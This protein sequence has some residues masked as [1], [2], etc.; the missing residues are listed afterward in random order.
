M[1]QHRSMRFYK[2]ARP[3]SDGKSR[4]STIIEEWTFDGDL[5]LSKESGPEALPFCFPGCHGTSALSI[6]HTDLLLV[7]SIEDRIMEA[8]NITQRHVWWM[9]LLHCIR[10]CMLNNVN[11]P[12]PIC[13]GRRGSDVQGKECT[14]Q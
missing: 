14:C 9:K 6:V 5:S 12:L 11:G 2:C 1:Q 3:A 13:A 4:I 10:Y 7:G 8:K